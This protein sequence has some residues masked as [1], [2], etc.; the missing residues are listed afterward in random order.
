MEETVD[1]AIELYMKRDHLTSLKV[2]ITPTITAT[3]V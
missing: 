1:I 3:N 2:K